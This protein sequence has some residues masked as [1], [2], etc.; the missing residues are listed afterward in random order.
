MSKGAKGQAPRGL[1]GRHELDVAVPRRA[2]GLSYK[3]GFANACTPTD[4]DAGPRGILDHSEEIG[5]LLCSTDHRPTVHIDHSAESRE[6]TE[7]REQSVLGTE[8][9]DALRLH[10][11]DMSASEFDEL[12]HAYRLGLRLRALG[13]DD[14]L[15]AECLGLGVHS[16]VPLLDIAALKLKNAQRV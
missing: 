15:I 12:P 13:A 10:D 11:G 3:P 2:D 16:I 4:D 8:D 9:P 6:Q 1:G 5:G 7:S 14:E